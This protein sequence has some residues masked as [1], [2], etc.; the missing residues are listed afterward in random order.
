VVAVGDAFDASGVSNGLILSNGG[1]APQPAA[2]TAGTTP[3]LPTTTPAAL[4]A[5]AVDQFFAAVAKADQPL[6]VTGHRSRAHQAA[7]HG[8]LDVSAW[9]IGSWDRS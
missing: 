6:S 3:A 1:K 7:D 2:T 4:D 8:A 5:N 9:D